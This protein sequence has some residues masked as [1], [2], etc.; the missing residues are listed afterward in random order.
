MNPIIVLFV[1]L[2]A[3]FLWFTLSSLFRLIGGA[4]NSLADDARY[5]MYERDDD[6]EEN[7]DE[8]V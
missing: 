5:A 6:D 2:F 3:I 7:N 1:I 4:F 8:G